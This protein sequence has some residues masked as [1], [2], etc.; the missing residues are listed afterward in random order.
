M[1]FGQR[2]AID[3]EVLREDIDHAP[4]HRAP[5]G[6]DAVAGD[7]LLLHA[8][9]GAAMGLEHVVFFEA[10]LIEQQFDALTRGQLALGVL[11]VDPALTSA[12]ARG[13][14]AAFKFG[15]HIGHGRI[16]SL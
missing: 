5:A 1:G 7:V 2:T 8:E 9:I 10:A 11:T 16:P 3:G 15:E 12:K 6:D 4:V 13:V 14:A